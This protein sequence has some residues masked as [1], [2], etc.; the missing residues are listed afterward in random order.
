MNPSP[1]PPRVPAPSARHNTNPIRPAL[2]N[3]VYDI[4]DGE[5]DYQDAGGGNAARDPG[6]PSL[7]VGNLLL[8]M[9]RYLEEARKEWIRP[10]GNRACLP[11]VRKVTALG[12]QLLEHHGAPPREWH[13]PDSAAI[14][15]VVKISDPGDKTRPNRAQQS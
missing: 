3:A 7:S 12:V 11:D 13:V 15:G 8:L 10:G 4:L 5:R 6:S 14:T 2:R 9:G 1:T